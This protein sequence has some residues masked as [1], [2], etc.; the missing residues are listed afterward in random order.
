MAIEM[1]RPRSSGIARVSRDIDDL[2]GRF[3]RD[4]PFWPGGEATWSPAVDM[5]DRKDEVVLRADLPGLE[6]RDINVTIEN[7]MLTIRG[8][9]TEAQEQQA[10]EKDYYCCER[11]SGS[12]F[13]SMTLPPGVDTN[14]IQATFKN[15]VLEIHIPKT[16]EAIGRKI[17]VKAA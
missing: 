7:N 9:W 8:E 17:E 3:F 10:E 13:R 15:G 1:W 4:L 2:F 6:Q 11:W 16:R 12:F 5:M 14:K